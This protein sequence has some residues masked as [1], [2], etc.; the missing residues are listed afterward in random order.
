MSYSWTGSA[1]ACWILLCGYLK[2]QR[3]GFIKTFD[4]NSPSASQSVESLDCVLPLLYYL[5]VCQYPPNES[6]RVLYLGFIHFFCITVSC[7]VAHITNRLN[8]PPDRLII[9]LIF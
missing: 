3:N 4:L 2:K 1:N 5:D 6:Q 7:V 8:A 9:S